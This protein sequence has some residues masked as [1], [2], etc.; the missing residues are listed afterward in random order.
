MDSK[1]TR[2]GGVELEVPLC[3]AR[4]VL[5][6]GAELKNAPCL[7]VGRTARLSADLGPMTGPG[8]Y[9][10]FLAEVERLRAEVEAPVIAC[11]AHP[12]YAASRHA[13][14]LSPAP[15]TVQHHHAHVVACMAEHGLT[16][17]VVG[18]AADGTGWGEDG[19]VWG[20]EV[21]L[22]DERAFRRAGRLRT[23][24][25]PG[26]DAAAVQTHR[27]GA[28]AVWEVWGEDWPE[29]AEACFASVDRQALAGLRGLLGGTLAGQLRTSSTGRL[30]DAA[31]F[32]LG[33]CDRNDTEAAAP[34]ALQQAAE[35]W[36]GQVEPLAY[37]VVE[38]GGLMEL[39]WRPTVR[40]M[41]QGRA[42]GRVAEE[43]ARAFHETLAGLFATG[44]ERAAGQGG[45]DRVVLTGGC[46]VNGLLAGRLRDRL[47]RAGLKVY[48]HEKLSAGDASV[49][50]GQAVVAAAR[51][52]AEK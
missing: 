40:E 21:L 19:T 16:G 22:A 42:A 23:M 38:A 31:A 26:G 1:T 32:L 4:P 46:M 9:R 8:A 30:F 13:R 25:L 14:T 39:D 52:G 7:L 3:A 18:I 35:A 45:T 29:C 44:A 20:G 49:A 6:V 34:I 36:G 37:A 48:A 15:V 50:V 10:A 12:D 28:A 2:T 51:D 5:A 27:P 33:L 43:L 47:E 41:L 11:D 24:V 17:T